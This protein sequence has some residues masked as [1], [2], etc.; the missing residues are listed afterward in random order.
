MS[1]RVISYKHFVSTFLL[2]KCTVDGE[3]DV[4]NQG[5]P[6]EFL[7]AFA[8][9]TPRKSACDLTQISH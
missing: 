9:I 1:A 8:C 4:R 5:N 7:L 3:E 6:I 2:N